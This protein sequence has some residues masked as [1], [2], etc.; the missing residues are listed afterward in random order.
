MCQPFE[1]STAVANQL[2][3]STVNT[4]FGQ[5]DTYA[6][7]LGIHKCRSFHGVGNVTTLLSS[8]AS[9]R[10]CAINTI[11][12]KEKEHSAMQAG[13]CA[14]NRLVHMSAMMIFWPTPNMAFHAH[15]VHLTTAQHHCNAL[16]TTRLCS[17]LIM[18][19]SHCL[20]VDSSDK[21]AHTIPWG[22]HTQ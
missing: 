5:L 15:F 19:K 1:N 8:V 10:A 6:A 22:Q 18:L 20:V 17:T 21:Q 7:C 2:A 4:H 12:S 14:Q 11:L 3:V 13:C 9:Y 16:H